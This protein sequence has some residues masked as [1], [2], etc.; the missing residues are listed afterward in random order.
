MGGRSVTGIALVFVGIALVYAA[1]TGNLKS[2]WVGLQGGYKSP[3]T[4]TTGQDAVADPSVP[5][6]GL[7]QGGDGGDSPR[8]YVGTT[9]SMWA[10]SHGTL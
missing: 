2:A 9:G 6:P 4:T 7:G 1:S 8:Y 10:G 5:S 3:P